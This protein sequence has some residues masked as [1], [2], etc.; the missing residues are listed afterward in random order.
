MFG[1]LQLGEEKLQ[2]FSLLALS[3]LKS[4]HD[5]NGKQSAKKR[6]QES[7]RMKMFHFSPQISFLLLEKTP[8]N[9]CH[10]IG[11]EMRCGSSG[12]DVQ[13]QSYHCRQLKRRERLEQKSWQMQ[14]YT[15]MLQLCEMYSEKWVKCRVLDSA[16]ETCMNF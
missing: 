11:K 3:K 7:T 5:R 14:V 16:T 15:I 9:F 4:N 10:R 8:L 12:K 2:R 6:V 1:R 13:M